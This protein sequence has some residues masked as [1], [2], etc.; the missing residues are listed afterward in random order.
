MC[1]RLCTPS[2]C[3]RYRSVLNLH[4]DRSVLSKLVLFEISWERVWLYVPHLVRGNWDVHGQMYG[5]SATTVLYPASGWTYAIIN[6][7]K[8]PLIRRNSAANIYGISR[9]I[10]GIPNCAYI[11][12]RPACK[13]YSEF[14]SYWAKFQRRGRFYHRKVLAGFCDGIPVLAVVLVFVYAQ[15]RNLSTQ[16]KKWRLHLVLKHY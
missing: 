4:A 12:G 2:I 10:D 5:C 1:L 13:Y 11:L 6:I 7:D 3:M 14:R 16:I 9:Q 15:L 8:I